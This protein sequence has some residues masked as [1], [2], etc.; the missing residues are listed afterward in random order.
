[1]DTIQVRTEQGI[2]E[3]ERKGEC[4][5]FRG[6][7]YAEPPVGELRFRAPGRKLPWTG[8]RKALEFGNACPQPDPTKD[9]FWHKEFY[10][11]KDYPFPNMSEDCLYLNI[12]AP[13]KK[14]RY[15]VALWIHGGSFDHGCGS[16]MEFDGRKFAANGVILV[17]IN[18]R[19]GVFGFF[20]DETLRRENTHRTTGNYGLLDQ[21]M[22]LQW[23]WKNIHNFGGDADR[24]TVFGQSAGAI[25]VQALVSSPLTEGLIHSAILQSGGGIDNGLIR[26][27]SLNQTYEE[28][29]KIMNLCG[30]KN[31]MQMRKLPAEKLVDVLPSLYE[32]QK[33]LLFE[34]VVDDYVLKEDI[35]TAA[36]NGRIHDIPYMI[37][38]TGN[39]IT[40]AKN[41]NGRNSML[42]Q[43]CEHFCRARNKKSKKPVYMYYFD[44]KLPGDDAGAFHSSDLWYIFGTLDRC[45]RP[46]S[47]RDYRLSDTMITSWS[48]FIKYGD[49]GTQ[50]RP[51]IQKTKFIRTFQ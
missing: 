11:N 48:N 16:E 50:W 25:C 2:L 41:E 23:V 10:G 24:I 45:W 7:P 36:Q 13:V 28:G 42:Y 12:W 14:G 21:I 8:V 6:V 38:M 19:T 39:D 40:V 43:G 32:E 30:V 1:M 47:G 44:R 46:M 27:V 3:G 9:P 22:A 31:A 33:G 49:P 17:T 37:G 5:I 4:M 35:E 15:P 34:P 29:K 51:Y 18:Y 26:R 20:A